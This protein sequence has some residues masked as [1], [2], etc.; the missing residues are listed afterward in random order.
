MS[1]KI[2]AISYSWNEHACYIG[3]IYY[4]DLKNLVDVDSDLSMNR[5]IDDNRVEK[6]IDYLEK[7]NIESAFFPP[8]V[9]SSGVKM[10]YDQT[11][12]QLE[13]KNG[14]FTIIDGQHR[15]KAIT[16]FE[17]RT[18]GN[19]QKKLNTMELPVLIVEGLESYQHRNLFSLINESAK[20]VDGN[21]SERFS[22][23]IENLIGLKFMSDN[24]DF[25]EYI[26][27][28]KKQSFDESKIAYIHMTDC[29]RELHSELYTHLKD[30]LTCPIEL[31]YKDSYYY[32]LMSCFL[33]RVL[34]YIVSLDTDQK[35]FFTKKIALRAIIEDVCTEIAELFQT[36]R[37]SSLEIEDCVGRIK[38]KIEDSLNVVLNKPVVS[39]T[40][41]INVRLTTYKSL[42]HFL[43]LNGY[44]ALHEENLEDVRE[45]I[46]KILDAYYNADRRL[47]LSKDDYELF[48]NTINDVIDRKSDLNNIEDKILLEVE[49]TKQT[50]IEDIIERVNQEENAHA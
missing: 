50:K 9:L 41:E 14:K 25:K 13:I 40:G 10:N 3:K 1:R 24:L 5:D 20:K 44:L 26:E 15:I 12:A 39:Y 30:H 33:N 49:I 16:E 42:R 43:R 37:A 19:E 18:K 8:A 23:K 32:E 31:L 27:W 36:V 11:K 48:R 29:I 2:S 38:E 21:I 7:Q 22:E 34:T 17:K 35:K 6:I 28:E 45:L 46:Q 47:E 4:R